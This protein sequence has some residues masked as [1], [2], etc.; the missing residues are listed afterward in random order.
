MLNSMNN[1]L[2]VKT[3]PFFKRDAGVAKKWLIAAILGVYI[4]LPSPGKCASPDTPHLP[5]E[6]SHSDSLVGVILDQDIINNL[7]DSEVGVLIN[8]GKDAFKNLPEGICGIVKFSPHISVFCE[9]MVN[10]TTAKSNKAPCEHS[11]YK[12]PW[13][14]IILVLL[15]VFGTL[16][17][18]VSYHFTVDSK[19]R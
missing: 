10:E 9:Q 14:D 18:S 6:A 11:R 4:L 13:H 1:I 3:F 12:I 16:V 17:G 7:T 19:Y 8:S 5:T 15:G 2:S